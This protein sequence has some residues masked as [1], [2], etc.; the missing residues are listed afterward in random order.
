MTKILVIEDEVTI[1]E[2][3]VEILEMEGFEVFD[4]DNGQTGITL[5]RTHL[6]DLVICDIMMPKLDGYSV[7]LALQDDPVTAMVPFIFLTAKTQRS[8]VRQGME[9]GA[10]DYL[11]KPFTADELLT[12]IHTRLKKKTTTARR[13][14]KK[15]ADLRG[16]IIH[17]LPHEF[18]TPLVSIMGYSELLMW[19]Y[20]TLERERIYDM[21]ATI[22]R[23]CLRLHRLIEN[24][25]IYAQIELL[26]ADTDRRRDLKDMWVS[27]PN[28]LVREVSQDKARKTNR[29]G[30]LQ[31]DLA[32]DGTIQIVLDDFR[33]V[34]DELVDNAFKF[35]KPGTPV[36]VSAGKNDQT[37]SVA[38]YNQGHGMTREQ[39]ADIGAGMQFERRLH[40]QQGA[41]M[42]LVIAKRLTELHGGEL[43][44]TSVP[45]EDITVRVT[46]AL[47][48]QA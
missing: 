40:E 7:L 33:K 38:I 5:A 43:A 29:D 37:Y 25:L 16:N 27:Q 42:G 34:V 24:F 15:L 41:G 10:D 8:D 14:E 26:S 21:A 1:L 32:Q 48:D 17:M 30:D 44:I 36:H 35:S 11:T 19:D 12:A 18:R 45:G 4:A 23:S 3:I 9:L 20:E 2:N 46:L 22:N 31:L 39:I 47:G 28:Q 6:P 13:Y